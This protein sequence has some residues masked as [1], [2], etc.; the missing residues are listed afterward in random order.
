MARLDANHDGLLTPDELG[1]R[2]ERLMKADM[3][4]DG[5]IDPQELRGFFQ[6]M[7]DERNRRRPG[8]PPDGAPEPP[9]PPQPGD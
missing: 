5:K 4:H 7:K 6:H 2:G 9:P 8:P 3:N 1:E